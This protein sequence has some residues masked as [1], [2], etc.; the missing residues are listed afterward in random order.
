LA[1]TRHLTPETLPFWRT[2]LRITNS[3]RIAPYTSPSIAGDLI[4]PASA[5]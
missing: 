4:E 2:S 1:N 3:L 5:R